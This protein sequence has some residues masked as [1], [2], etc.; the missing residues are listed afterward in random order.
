MN[1][2]K[3]VRNVDENSLINMYIFLNWLFDDLEFEKKLKM[4]REEEMKNGK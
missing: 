3:E 4:K 2:K 1:E